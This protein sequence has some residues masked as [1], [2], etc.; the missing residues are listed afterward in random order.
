MALNREESCLKR[1]EGLSSE[2]P[3]EA[4]S[5]IC[6]V[7]WTPGMKTHVNLMAEGYLEDRLMTY[8]K[9][10]QDAVS[11][12]MEGAET[13]GTLKAKQLRVARTETRGENCV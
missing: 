5:C 4:D 2:R 12:R 7:E 13:I 1:S 11:R 10:V 6:G 8:V 9:E 3:Q